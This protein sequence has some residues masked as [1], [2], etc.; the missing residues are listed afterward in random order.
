MITST[1]GIDTVQY[2]Q[3]RHVF[4]MCQWINEVMLSM[5]A[6]DDFDT[7]FHER[8]GDN[9]KKFIEEAI[10]ISRLG[11]YFS[12]VGNDVQ[13][14]CL[15][16][17]Q[18]YDATL[19]S[20]GNNNFDIRIEVTT[21]ETHDSTERRQALARNGFAYTS[22]TVHK[23]GRNITL[24]PEF[25]NLHDQE[26]EWANIAF[27]RVLAKLEKPYTS[28]T[29][30]LVNIDK[31]RSLSLENR[32][33]LIRRTHHRLL[34]IDKEVFGVYYLHAHPLHGVVIDGVKRSDS[35]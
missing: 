10:P 18:N 31:Y 23:E 19:K 9:V 4:E 32:A 26:E 11:L 16:G 21:C 34:T 5:Q 15:T 2:E 35:I 28:D 14:S 8:K 33:Q 1:F 29:A 12:S 20:T 22:G 24:Q 25:V 30:I 3:T 13:I 7:I 27:D 6:H 17:S